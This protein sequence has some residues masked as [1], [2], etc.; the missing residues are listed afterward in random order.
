MRTVGRKQLL[1]FAILC[2][3]SYALYQ[4]LL[5]EQKTDSL[6]PFTKGYALYDSILQMSNQ[7][8]EINT[9][10][11]SPK[12]IHY[13]DT[14]NT[15]LKQPE[16]WLKQTGED[17]RFTSAEATINQ[18]REIYFPQPVHLQAEQT[19]GTINSTIDTEQLTIFSQQKQ[20]QTPAKI[21][22]KQNGMSLSGTAATIDLEQKKIEIKHNVY[23]EFNQ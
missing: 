11:K 7:Q 5:S 6:Q 9:V 14:E 23:A 20:A 17:W 1:W 15:L 3:V 4:L 10:I 16:I 18:Q 21:T 19:D 13:A 8:G 12:I 2:V 22:V